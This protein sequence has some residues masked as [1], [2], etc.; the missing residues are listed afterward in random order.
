MPFQKSAVYITAMSD[1]SRN[2]LGTT[3]TDSGCL[4]S[5]AWEAL[6][7]TPSSGA[8]PRPAYD[9]PTADEPITAVK[10]ECWT[11]REDRFTHDVFL[12]NHSQD[13]GAGICGNLAR[14]TSQEVRNQVLLGT[15]SM[16][17]Q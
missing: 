4:H 15:R 17:V 3:T 2:P 12:A 1:A 7:G 13:L 6:R 8:P 11:L 16:I 14:P 9:R 10:T 5:T